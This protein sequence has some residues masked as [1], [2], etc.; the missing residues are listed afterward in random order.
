MISDPK[1]AIIVL[2]WNKKDY[3]LGLL[4]FLKNMKYDNYEVVV[5]AREFTTDKSYER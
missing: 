1:V 3:V 4:D 5:V 2:N